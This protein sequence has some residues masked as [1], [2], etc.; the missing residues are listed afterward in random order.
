TVPEVVAKFSEGLRGFSESPLWLCTKCYRDVLKS[1]TNL[2][3]KEA[4][5]IAYFMHSSTNDPA[6]AIGFEEDEMGSIIGTVQKDVSEARVLVNLVGNIQ[7]T[8]NTYTD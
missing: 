2:T 5:A 8:V 7:W 1:N 3:D 4:T 6:D